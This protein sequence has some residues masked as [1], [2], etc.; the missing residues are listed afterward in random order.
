[1]LIGF[2]TSP[3]VVSLRTGV[4]SAPKWHQ[5]N[6]HF[7]IVAL[8]SFFH[9]FQSLDYWNQ[10]MLFSGNLAGMFVFRFFFIF[11]PIGSGTLL[12]VWVWCFCK[13]L[14][15]V[16]CLFN[17]FCKNN[18]G[19]KIILFIFWIVIKDLSCYVFNFALCFDCVLI[20]IPM[21][22]KENYG[23]RLEFE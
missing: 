3:C 21:Y 17:S 4:R 5:N 6:S 10:R 1:M 13:N 22:I 18:N 16:I 9:F 14:S 2:D 19:G 12:V 11:A 7:K 20:S 23:L 15:W 8:K